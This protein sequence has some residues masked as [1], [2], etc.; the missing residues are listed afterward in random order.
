MQALADAASPRGGA[1]NRDGIIVFAPTAAGPIYRISAAGG[2]ATVLTQPQKPAQSDHRAPQFL[3]DGRHFLY[4]ARG[5]AEGRGVYVGGLDGS[6][7]P[8]LVDADAGAVYAASGHLLFVRQGTLFAVRFDVDHLTLVGNP[9]PVAQQVIVSGGTSLAALSASAAGPIIYRAGAIAQSQLA[10]IDRSGKSLEPVGDAG[11]L[12][13]P[14]LSPDGRQVVIGRNVDSNWDLWLLDTA[15]GVRTRLTSDPAIDL[16][17]VW[18]P[19]GG[20]VAFSSTRK[21]SISLYT[22]SLMGTGQED[23]L[24]NTVGAVLTDWSSDGRFLLYHKPGP[25]SDLDLWAL[26]LSADRA[27]LPVAQSRF[28]ERDGQFSP[29]GKWIAYGSDESGRSEIYVQPFP[30]PG[31]KIQVSTAGGAQVRWRGDGKELFY[32]A[33]DAR[34]MAVPMQL[35]ST[36]QT[37]VAG[38][39][40]SLFATHIGGAIQ[41]NITAQY[42]VARDGQRFLMNTVS[43]DTPPISVILNW[44]PKP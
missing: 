19:D 2:P 42:A 3:P 25:A 8:R 23:A 32:V 5:T 27:P 17:G 29:D 36:G 12:A 30:G 18:S 9:F 1:W 10:W 31:E 20:R 11:S 28:N 14:A 7:S 44:A 43:E 37:L 13:S 16:F 40:A 6:H 26:P 34:L 41:A 21:E 4:Y 38:R 39:P 22:K 15:R 35:P 24:P 33:L